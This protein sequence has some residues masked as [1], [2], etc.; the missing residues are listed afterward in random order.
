MSKQ[1]LIPHAIYHV[2]K[3]VGLAIQ[4]RLVNLLNITRKHHLGSLSG[5]RYNGFDFVRSKVLRLV[6]DAISLAQAPRINAKASITS[7]SLF[8]ISSRRFTSLELEAN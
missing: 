3:P 1:I 6:N 4:I 7:W 8:C 5:T 2:D